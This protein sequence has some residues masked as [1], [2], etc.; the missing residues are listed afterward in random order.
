MRVLITG[1]LTGHQALEDLLTAVPALRA[2]HQL[3][4]IAVIADNVSITGPTPI[5]GSGMTVA[6]RDILLASGV[7]LIL[8]GSHVWDGG[9]GPTA[10][11]HPRVLRSSNLI[12][13]ALPGQGRTKLRANGSTLDLLQLS[14]DAAPGPEATDLPTGWRPHRDNPPDVVHVVANAHTVQVFAHAVDGQVAAVVGSLSHIASRDIERLPR[15]TLLVPDIG[16]VGP[17]GGI[18]G[19]EPSHFLSAYTGTSPTELPPYHHS[20]GPTQFSGVILDLV[21]EDKPPA[22]TWLLALPSKRRSPVPTMPTTPTHQPG[23]PR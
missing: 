13:D 20:A 22:A 1:H 18:G 14:D 11:S 4:A 2:D 8:T 12:G 9:H 19:F 7:D 23:H 21:A 10:V 3:D 5:G 15:G 6:D 17:P 16:Y